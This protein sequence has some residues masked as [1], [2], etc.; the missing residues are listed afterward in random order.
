MMA[1]L[2]SEKG[3]NYDTASNGVEAIEAVQSQSYDVVLMDLQMPIMDGF[4]A[5]S[6]IRSWE[7]GNQHTPIVA[8]TAMLF[9]DEIRKC[10]SVGMDDCI[11]KPFNT[12]S[13]FQLIESY[14]GQSKRQAQKKDSVETTEVCEPVLLDIQN[15]LPRFSKDVEIYREFLNEFIDDLPQRINQFRTSFLSGDFTTLADSA[16]NLKGISA[17]MGAKHL[18]YLSQKLDQKSKDGDRSVVQQALDEVEQHILV[19][20]NEAIHILND[21]TGQQEN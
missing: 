8:L 21:F 3:Y 16:H 19:L 1:L 7:A 15:A 4:E 6:I 17:S 9:G 12:E 14:V 13:L 20:Q 10:L 18:S 11:S 5:T 2:L